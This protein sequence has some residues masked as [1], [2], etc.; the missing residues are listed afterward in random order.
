M[1]HFI[2]IADHSTEELN[3]LLDVAGRLKKQLK[4]TGRNDPILAGKTLA[5]VFEK[6]SLRTRVS[7]AVAMAQLGGYGLLLRQEEVGLGTRE[8]LEDVAR[9]LSGMCDG[10]MARTF[11]HEKVTGL[12]RWSSVPVIN[13]LTDYLHP[14]QAMADLMTLREHF[15][16]L[17]GRTLA[18]IGD[19]N[20]VARSLATACGKLGLKFVLSSPAGYELPEQ[21]VDRIMALLPN[22]EFE[23][24]RDPLE[25]V[26]SADAI[27]TDTWVSMGQEAEKARRVKDFAGYHIDER[28]MAAAPKHAVVLHCLPAYRGLEISAEVMEGPQS[29]IF[30]EAENRLH[31]QKGLLAVLMGGMK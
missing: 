25:A 17:E 29:L 7:F 9:I 20:N 15:G 4:E 12:A 23:L 2:S 21:D 26:R 24:V 16:N 22:M 8:P 13:G 3:H 11:E 18:F 14:C 19:G 5:M 10:I 27:Y 1:T 31:F 28:L 6:P 30:P